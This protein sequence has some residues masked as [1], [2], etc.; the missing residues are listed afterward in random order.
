[1]LLSFNVN[2]QCWLNQF[3][4]ISTDWVLSSGIVVLISLDNAGC[5]GAR[6]GSKCGKSNLART[7]ETAMDFLVAGGCRS[8]KS[9]SLWKNCG[10]AY[11]GGICSS[12]K[13]WILKSPGH[14]RIVV[15][16]WKSW[17]PSRWYCAIFT[18]FGNTVRPS[19]TYIS[20]SGCVWK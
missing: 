17:C 15:L 14:V 1:M 8:V 6:A 3:V 13:C 18:S 9:T 11:R 12:W 7:S 2:P 4:S 5:K 10:E 16:F 20:L 19:F